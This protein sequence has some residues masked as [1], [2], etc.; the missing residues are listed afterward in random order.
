MLDPALPRRIPAL[1]Q[2]VEKQ[3]RKAQNA[4]P[5]DFVDAHFAREPDQSRVIKALLAGR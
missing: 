3:N 1:L 2:E 4:K 5:E